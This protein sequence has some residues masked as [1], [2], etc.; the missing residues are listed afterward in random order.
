MWWCRRGASEVKPKKNATLVIRRGKDNDADPVSLAIRQEV[1]KTMTYHPGYIH[2]R[3][4]LEDSFGRSHF[5]KALSR[6]LVLPKGS[7]GLVVGIEG[8]WGSGK[9][10]L[11]GFITKS[12]GEITSG[13]P[14]VVEFNPWMVSNTGALVEA[15]IGQ[16]AASI[17][18]DLSNGKKGIETGQKLLNYVGLLKHLKY[19]PGL[20]WAGHAAEDIPDLVRTVASVA[21]QGTEAGQKA[22][23]DFKRLLPSLDISQKRA[24]VVAALDEL[25]HPIVIV[26]D[27]LDRLPAEEIRAMI[28]AIKAVADFPR[29]T[30]LLAYDRNVIARA[31]AA[32]EKSGLSYLEKIV[33]VAYPIPPSSQRQLKK[34][35]NDKVQD[36]LNELQITLRD[37]EQDRYEE[38]MTLLTKL[39][40]H[41]RDI[42]RVVNR[43][44]L[45]LPMTH[46]EVNAADVIVFEALS[47]RFPDLREAIRS[48]PVDFIGHPFRDDLIA[49]KDDFDWQE[50]LGDKDKDKAEQPW[51]RHL[52]KDK[53]DQSI[54]KKACL[55]LFSPQEKNG[56][57][58][59]PENYLGIAD[60]DR[61]AR[62]FR[63]I[64]IEDVPEAK[65][66][67]EL[68]QYPAK[69][70]NALH[71]IDDEQ[72]RFLLEWMINYAPSCSTPDVKGCVKELAEASVKL[73]EQCR[74]TDELAKKFADLMERLLR[75]KISRYEDCFLDIANSA[76]L[77]I[78]E[79]V[80]CTAAAEIGKWG[81]PHQHKVNDECQMISSSDI[82]DQAIKIWLAR[83]RECIAQGN[84][85][86]EAN[87]FSVLY[88]FAQFN[89]D[90]YEETYDAISKM[91][92]TDKGLAAFLKYFVEGSHFI[93]DRLML[94]ED[95]EKFAQRIAN[96]AL[97]DEYH[98]LVELLGKEETIKFVQKQTT[99]LKRQ[100]QDE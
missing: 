24:E 91:C 19:V 53:H 99:K 22:I 12:L 11:I 16:L 47:Q 74:L 73:T 30:Y 4:A 92:E 100:A 35:A 79:G 76:P 13:V 10:T 93:G 45:S 77:S 70:K 67:H 62:L 75:R 9:S 95:A 72:L 23:G 29:I 88:R 7:P 8:D 55:F 85:Y 89:N 87:L 78:S 81:D 26:I 68:L 25:D 43:L 54:S 56:R 40:R 58:V 17:G 98:W 82:V 59:I 15:L 34:F 38:A 49:V 61:L 2:D 36:L 18:K 66:I 65:E 46:N 86:K 64:S 41:P 14:I 20:S 60:P 48:H 31:L 94:A 37:F 84:L 33:Q 90:A 57:R 80:V 44:T 42:I 71:D 83:V 1:I 3:P 97:K 52:P 27:D 32:D 96:S 5:A 28:Q 21:A 69:L 39:S 6:S 63:M 51:L 50:Y